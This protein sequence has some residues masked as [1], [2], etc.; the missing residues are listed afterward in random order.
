MLLIGFSAPALAR[1]HPA[2]QFPSLASLFEQREHI[3]QSPAHRHAARAA[4]HRSSY[5]AHR[6]KSHIA[7]SEGGGVSRA[8][9]T[10]DTRDL[11]DRVE[12]QFGPV[13][14]V[15]T[16]RPGASIAGTHHPSQHR[17]GRAVDF[18]APPGRKADVV[19][20]LAANNR[21]GTMTYSGMSHIHMDT[22]PY[23]F[24]SLGAPERGSVRHAR[25]HWYVGSR[26]YAHNAR[27]SYTYASV[28]NGRR[29]SREDGLE[30]LLARVFASSR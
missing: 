18:N 5:A 21:G 6:G 14:I 2:W 26:R 15:S 3:H 29:A 19:N 1:E 20:W 25:A 13:Q 10:S 27:H 11:L 4:R 8:C 16:C 17:Y 12:A 23:H 22:G 24:V 28:H 9:L 7:R 30:R